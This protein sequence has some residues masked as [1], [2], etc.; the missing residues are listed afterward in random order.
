MKKQSV[1]RQ[2]QLR[3]QYP[4]IKSLFDLGIRQGERQVY[5]NVER[6]DNKLMY[7]FINEADGIT[8]Y[9][10]NEEGLRG[11]RIEVYGSYDN[12][13]SRIKILKDRQ[14]LFT[15]LDEPEKVSYILKIVTNIWHKVPSSGLEKKGV[16]LGEFVR[17]ERHFTVYLPPKAGFVDLIS[18]LDI[19]KN[20]YITTRLMLEGIVRNDTQVKKVLNKLESVIDYFKINVYDKGGLK[21]I[22]KDCRYKGMSGKFGSVNMRS[23]CMAGRLMI[24]I[25]S[26]GSANLDQSFTI[27]GDDTSEEPRFGVQSLYATCSRVEEMVMEVV[28]EW[29]KLSPEERKKSFVRDDNISIV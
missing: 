25:Q 3:K 17:A 6:A 12:T 16:Y 29:E 20:V 1:G 7:A 28:H 11:S 18:N 23:C 15:M 27:L 21:T 9:T 8:S 10:S 26:A 14:F 13:H 4:P 22:I 24:T 5:I 19:T 2:N